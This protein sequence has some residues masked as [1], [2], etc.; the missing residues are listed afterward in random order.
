MCTCFFVLYSHRQKIFF[1]RVGTKWSFSKWLFL[2]GLIGYARAQIDTIIV[3]KFFNS[4]LIGMYHLSRDLAMFPAQN[5][6]SPAIEPLLTAFQ[7]IK[8]NKENL[9]FQVRFCLFI[10]GLISF[11]IALFL[12]CSFASIRKEDP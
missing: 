6:L 7:K 10:V 8:E 3:A 5:I 11:P 4:S 12:L 1:S 9:E 2:K